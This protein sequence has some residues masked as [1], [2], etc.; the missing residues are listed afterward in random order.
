VT[1]YQEALCN[2]TVTE[3]FSLNMRFFLTEPAGGRK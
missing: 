3:G 1:T 2:T